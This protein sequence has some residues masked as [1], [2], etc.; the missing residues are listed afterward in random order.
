MLAVSPNSWNK[1]EKS[2]EYPTFTVTKYE[3]SSVS[4][5]NSNYTIK[6]GDDNYS[7]STGITETT[8]F[9]LWIGGNKVDS[10]TVTAVQ[11]G[12]DSDRPGPPGEKGDDGKTRG[13]ITLYSTTTTMNPIPG[14]PTS[15]TIGNGKTWQTNILSPDSTNKFVWETKGAY[16]ENLD[17]TNRTYDSNWT[18]PELH[19]AYYAN[20]SGSTAAEYYKLFGTDIDNNGMKYNDDGKLFINATMI[21]TGTLT[22]TDDGSATGEVLFS[23]GWNE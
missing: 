8:T 2:K 22:I 18:T 5:I 16:T 11:N 4:T 20:I 10:E 23:A 21:N 14:K 1:T 12:N 13:T 7:S 19:S 17:G 3:G 15:S 6:V 9:D